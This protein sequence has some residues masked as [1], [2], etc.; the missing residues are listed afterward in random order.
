MTAVRVRGIV[1]AVLLLVYGWFFVLQEQRQAEYRA[2]LQYALPASFYRVVTGF[3]RQLAAEMLFIRTS[4]FLGGIPPGVPPT[5][6]EVP[7]ANNFAVMTDLYPRFIDPYYFT[8]GFL[9]HISE[10]SAARA[11]EIF[12][13]GI[14]AHPDDFV[15]RFFHGSTFFL[16]MDE[17]LKAAQAFQEA[18]D[19]PEAPPIFA[20]LAA[21]LSA[22]G[23]NI[24]AGLITLQAMHAGE[25][26]EA[27]RQRYA[28]EIAI[29]QEA[30]AVQQ[31]VDAYSGKYGA[32]PEALD[33]LVPEFL[34][35]VPEIRDAF[36]LVY[37][38]PIVH[39]KR[40]ERRGQ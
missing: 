8:Q 40:P 15:L 18:A 32:P 25:A 16:A 19:L 6:Y 35:E 31:A 9:P 29:F 14:A 13:T 12:A 38:P 23:G 34:G 5:S 17:P 7:L 10:E 21:I 33:S 2:D 1:V 24:A 37:T 22:R 26:D 4:V 27:V 20:R 11:A 30:L 39:L 36:E 3:G 28:E